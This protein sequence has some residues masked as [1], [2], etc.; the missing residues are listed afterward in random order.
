MDVLAHTVPQSPPR[1][2]EF[3]SQLRNA[4]VALIPTLTL[5]DFEARKG[6]SSDQ[7]REA[8]IANMVAELR[9]YSESGRWH[10][11]WHRYWLHRPLRYRLGIHAY[12]AG[13]N[14][15][16]ANSSFAHHESG[17]KLGLGHSDRSGRIAKGMDADLV[18][19]DGDPRGDATAFSKV[20]Q[21]IRGGQMI[22]PVQ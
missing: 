7:E 21:V 14:E 22:Y 12:V 13:R 6:N 10:S 16:S 5:F 2:P 11:I 3:V 1:T 20:H 19:L 15:L 9:A 18:V 8:W 4:N 17:R